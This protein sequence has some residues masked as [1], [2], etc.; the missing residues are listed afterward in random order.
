MPGLDGRHRNKN[1]EISHKHGNILIR[2]PL[3]AKR[4]FRLGS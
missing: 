2:T 4:K 3:I 1:G